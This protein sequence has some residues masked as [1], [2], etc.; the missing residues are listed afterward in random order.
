MPGRVMIVEDVATNRLI[1]R[2]RLTQSYYDVVEAASGEEALELVHATTPDI[3]L[4]DVMMPGIDGFE[5]CR[6]LKSDPKTLHIPVVMLTALDKLDDRVKGLE[7]G[8]DDFLSKPFEDVALMSRVASLTRMKM[9]VDELTL[10]GQSGHDYDDKEMLDIARAT[11][12]KG[13]DMLIVSGDSAQTAELRGSLVGALECTVEIAETMDEALTLLEFMPFDAIIV[14]TM[15]GGG[16]PLRLGSMVRARPETRQAATLLLLDE[17]DLDT[18][19][20]AL[21]LGF[22]D[23]IASPVD[24]V[25]LIARTRCSLRRKHFADKLRERM[26]A[27]MV[28]AVTD[29][30]TGTYN[31]R[32]ANNHLDTLIE[33]SRASGSELAVMMLDID[34]FK[35]IND[36]YG[37][38]AGDDVLREFATRLQTNVREMDLVARMGGEEF[39]VVMPEVND[40][41]V[42]EIAERVRSSIEA[43]LFDVPEIDGSRITVSIGYGVLTSDESASDLI[44]RADLALYTSKRDGRNRVSIAAAA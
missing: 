9:L 35:R 37:H 8:A 20:Q 17:H 32:Y 27:T 24:M 28:H 12:F 10:R 14:G 38:T 3:I 21:D 42:A 30:L 5:V 25:E 4:L 36:Q 13:S 29:P 11:T 39:M 41:L 2:S 16:D 31:R 43:P 19:T 40:M 18:A 1:L 26:R 7:A 15:L 22:N 23:Y 34:H 44:N 33:R 6:R